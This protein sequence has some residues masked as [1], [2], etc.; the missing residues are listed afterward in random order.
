[1]F[2]DSI[3]STALTGDVPD[4][5]L[6][7]ISCA[8]FRNDVSFL[9][10][11]RAFLVHR[12]H[13]GEKLSIAFETRNGTWSPIL[14]VPDTLLV[15]NIGGLKE[16][17][18]KAFEDIDKTFLSEYE[19]FE[20]V[21]KIRAFYERSFAAR[22]FVNKA[23]KMSV[24]FVD[25]IDMRTLHCLECSILIMLPWYHEREPKLTDDETALV[26]CLMNKASTSS[27]Y[28]K[29][30][31]KIASQFDF[32]TTAIKTMLKGFAVKHHQAQ[33][34]NL[35][36]HIDSLNSQLD[37]LMSEIGSI[38][39]QCEDDMIRIM[40]LEAAIAKG[41]GD[42]E[43]MSFILTHENINIVK[44]IERGFQITIKTQYVPTTETIAEAR[45][46]LK[47]SRTGWLEGRGTSVSEE[48]MKSLFKAIFVDRIIKLNF[49][50]SY[51]VT[52][53]TDMYRIPV[54]GYEFG[55]EF[56]DYMPN[57]HIN[58]HRCAGDYVRDWSDAIVRGDLIGVIETCIASAGSLNFGDGIVMQSFMDSMYGY[59]GRKVKALAL[60]DGRV[61]TPEDAVAWIKEQKGE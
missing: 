8:G 27:D 1:M 32:R 33:L 22:C 39:K 49:C 42:D 11:A 50:A 6:G 52:L 53:S 35:R 25:H 47:S 23:A 55:P 7:H 20:E 46:I 38:N 56:D 16:Q 36:S 26:K 24:V 57:P 15:V 17:A 54:G 5:S 9:A 37:N 58:I 2:R 21:P 4:M 59:N 61:V 14:C 51:N 13:E 28:V 60:P 41:E 44:M 43:L 45:N 12:M 34:S 29:C 3:T 18:S 10:S 30:I 48:D 40:G 31:E 19:G